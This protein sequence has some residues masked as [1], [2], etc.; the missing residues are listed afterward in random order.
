MNI[1]TPCTA[2]ITWKLPTKTFKHG[3][4]TGIPGICI[5]SSK[6]YQFTCATPAVVFPDLAECFMKRLNITLLKLSEDIPNI[7]IPLS[8][9]TFMQL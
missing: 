8:V 2:V 1:F 5:A 7:S 9:C 4:V 6:F 3:D